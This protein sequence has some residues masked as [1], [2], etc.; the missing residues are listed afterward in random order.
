VRIWRLVGGTPSPCSAI[1]I[2]NPGMG[3]AYVAFSPNGQY[4]AVA[5]RRD[6]VYVYSVPSFTMVGSIMSSYGPLYGVG[7]SPDSQTVFSVDYDPD[8]YDGTLYAD[9]INGDSIALAQAGVDPDVLAVSPVAGAGNTSTIAIGGYEGTSG[10]YVFDGT[11]IT[12]PTIVSMGTYVAAWSARFNPAGNLL[13]IGTDDGYVRFW[14]IPLTSTTQAGSPIDV[15]GVVTV[16][17]IAFSPQGTH[18]AAA[19]DLAADI[20]N[21]STRAFVSATITADAAE[22]ITFSASGSALITGEHS[23]GRILICS[24]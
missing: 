5:W 22:S 17:G 6:Y 10:V 12:G 3:P 19:Y 13:A 11:T 16:V 24:D 15:G 23:C 14:N 1:D 21:V 18:I 4:L 9:R 20:Y 8:Y 7:F 2:S